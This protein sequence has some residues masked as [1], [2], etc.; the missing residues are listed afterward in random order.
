MDDREEV[1][2][3]GAVEEVWVETVV[4]VEFWVAQV[5]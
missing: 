2:E 3:T 1:V 5:A 4:V